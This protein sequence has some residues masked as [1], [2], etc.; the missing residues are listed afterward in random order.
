MQAMI[1]SSSLTFFNFFLSASFLFY[2]PSTSK[3]SLDEIGSTK[4][5]K[6]V[7]P[8]EKARVLSICCFTCRE[9]CVLFCCS[10][11]RKN[12]RYRMLDRLVV[13]SPN[14]LQVEKPTCQKIIGRDLTACGGRIWCPRVSSK[15][16]L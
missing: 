4:H 14:R 2:Y 9:L 15:S 5:K 7:S 3:V 6:G 1:F 8:F 13:R 12:S 10:L 11:D 16:S